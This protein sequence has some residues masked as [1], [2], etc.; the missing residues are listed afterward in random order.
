MSMH[1]AKLRFFFVYVF[2]DSLELVPS[3]SFSAR[4]CASSKVFSRNDIPI[5]ILSDKASYF[6][7]DESQ[8]QKTSKLVKW[9][10]NTL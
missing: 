1:F 4:V 3:S 9:D 10:F 5:T 2:V 6:V 7:V 8:T